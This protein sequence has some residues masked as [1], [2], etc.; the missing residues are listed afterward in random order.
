MKTMTF[1]EWCKANPD[2]VLEV[3]GGPHPCGVTLGEVADLAEAEGLSTGEAR[4]HINALLRAQYD[5]QVKRDKE[6]LEKWNE[7]VKP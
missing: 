1:E 4:G 5:A 6:K 7:A 3:E 2:L